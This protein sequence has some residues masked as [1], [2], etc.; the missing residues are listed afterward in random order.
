MAIKEWL[1]RAFQ[2]VVCPQT[3]VL[4]EAS[5]ANADF[6]PL[7]GECLRS[8]K[9]FRGPVCQQCGVPVPGSILESYCLCSL[10]REQDHQFRRAKSWGPYEG[11]LRR[12]IHAF[13]FQGC[14]RLAGPL[15]SLLEQCQNRSPDPVDCIVPV[16]LHPRKRRQRGFDQTMLL[17]RVLS[18]RTLLPIVR[19]VRRVRY[20]VPQ[21]GL[22]YSERRRNVRGAFKLRRPEQIAGRRVLLIDDVMTTGATVEEVSRVLRIE[23]CPREVV[24]A[25]V[26]R[27]SRLLE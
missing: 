25:T 10:C 17:A 27:V 20:S 22:G 18:E 9:P 19:C 15:G 2:A 21:F 3:C 14:S 6:S 7:C 13:K 24:V 11:G 4:C 1:L 12:T 16:P 8:L 26:A 23:A 5:V